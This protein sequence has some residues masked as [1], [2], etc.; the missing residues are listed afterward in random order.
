[1]TDEEGEGGEEVEQRAYADVRQLEAAATATR[2]LAGRRKLKALPPVPT[3]AVGSGDTGASASA[4]DS[5]AG[6]TAG[7]GASMV[8]EKMPLSA[9]TH[10]S[11]AVKQLNGFFAVSRGRQTGK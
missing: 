8:A 7:P 4:T 6:P 9:T 2:K 11:G 3:A 1:M 10:G 5:T